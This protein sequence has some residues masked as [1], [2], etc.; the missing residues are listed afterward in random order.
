MLALCRSG[1]SV[2]LCSV[3]L[4][5]GLL[6]LNCTFIV[7]IQYYSSFHF[8]PC[9]NRGRIK[10]QLKLS[11][12]FR[13]TC[14]PIGWC[15]IG[16]VNFTINCGLSMDCEV[17]VFREQLYSYS[18]TGIL[19]VPRKPCVLCT[20]HSCFTRYWYPGN[21]RHLSADRDVFMRPCTET[22]IIARFACY[23]GMYIMF[24]TYVL[25]L[26]RYV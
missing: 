7:D 21:S 24:S 22:A 10:G 13:I 14:N 11:V 1:T 2:A 26:I 6:V 20:R 25:D 3:A 15:C 16:F 5:C 9:V 12:M 17:I 18:F 19:S 23:S 8:Q 4:L